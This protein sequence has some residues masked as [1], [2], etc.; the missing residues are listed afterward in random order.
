MSTNTFVCWEASQAE[1]AIRT[2]ALEG[3]EALFNAVHTPMVDIEVTSQ[4]EL[5]V[6][7]RTSDVELLQRISQNSLE[8]LFC[9]IRGEHGAGKSHLIRWLAIN[10]VNAG[11]RVLLLNRAGGNLYQALRQLRDDLGEDYSDLFNGLEQHTNISPEGQ[12]RNF[13][14]RLAN[15]TKK[16]YYERT[17]HRHEDWLEKKGVHEILKH[18]VVQDN[19]DAPNR[20]LDTLMGAKGARDSILAKFTVEDISKLAGL[21]RMLPKKAFQSPKPIIFLKKLQRE[22]KGHNSDNIPQD[23][24][25]VRKLLEALNDRLRDAVRELLGFGSE[26][27]Q[28]I[29]RR[30]RERLKQQDRRLVLLLEDITSTQGVDDQLLD[31]VTTKCTAAGNEVL[32]PLISIVGITPAYYDEHLQ[33]GN[34][35]DR[36]GLHLSLGREQQTEGFKSVLSSEVSQLEFVARYLRAIR[37]EPGQLDQ[38]NDDGRLGPPPNACDICELRAA[39]HDSFGA[40]SLNENDHVTAVG[41]F[42]FVTHSVTH[43]FALLR[44]SEGRQASQTPRRML[45][46]VLGPSLLSP[47]DLT[48]GSFPHP[49]IE[50][51]FH[52][53]AQRIPGA[54]IRKRLEAIA[55]QD[56]ELYERLRRLVVWWGDEH[57]HG[58]LGTSRF[59]GISE[60]VFER[61]SLPFPGPSDT[62]SYVEMTSGF[63]GSPA[64]P[65][66]SAEEPEHLNVLQDVGHKASIKQLKSSVN[67]VQKETNV[68]SKSKGRVKLKPDHLKD[69]ISELQEWVQ[70]KQLLGSI[71]KWRPHFYKTIEKLRWKR[72][73]IDDWTREKM[74]GAPEN[75]F[76]EGARGSSKKSQ[77][78]IPRASWVADGM[79]A[80]LRLMDD[81]LNDV[82]SFFHMRQY[83]F[84]ERKMSKLVRQ[85][86]EQMALTS[87]NETRWRPEVTFAEVLVVRAWLRGVTT[88][89]VPLD[90]QW[91]RALD[92]ELVLL[93]GSQE[94][95]N[96]WKSTLDEL[97]TTSRYIQEGL[98][99]WI[100]LPQDTNQN[101]K[102]GLVEMSDIA[103]ALVRLV[104]ERSI[105]SLPGDADF[106]RLDKKYGLLK[107]VHQ[108]GRAVDQ[109]LPHL[110]ER[111]TKRIQNVLDK[112]DAY[113]ENL[114]I[115]E[116]VRRV[117]A[118]VDEVRKRLP[119][120]LIDQTKFLDELEVGL[121]SIGYSSDQMLHG[122]PIHNV[123][124]FLVL[125][126]SGS[127]GVADTLLDIFGD[128]PFDDEFIKEEDPLTQCIEAPVYELKCVLRVLEDIERLLD[129][130]SKRL[131]DYLEEHRSEAAMTIDVVH[132]FGRT[133]EARAKVLKAYIEGNDDA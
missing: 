109:H 49:R 24:E 69:A 123:E 104:K 113:T 71:D 64:P 106:G 119:N 4:N 107:R 51:S 133:V 1:R 78:I 111:E 82:D 93:P 25:N 120:V 98:T 23:A 42:P 6:G 19:W 3:S 108:W 37:A 112:L 40:Y 127:G 12:A 20:I 41:L 79:E 22:L 52:P 91:D 125:R 105:V 74:F 103:P 92:R 94:R 60:G 43:M 50:T 73:G 121:K 83:A 61:F 48:N 99:A 26:G 34:M 67:R 97:N 101:T 27:V 30:L 57:A 126:L 14:D 32:C 76:I 86:V 62:K 33:A 54:R 80:F 35:R 46:S 65:I 44:D 122:A 129:T 59:M 116:Y 84:Y 81:D 117:Q 38:W 102:K 63:A 132:E 7:E 66:M 72:L 10:W 124:E 85:H 18:P 8:H 96:S 15:S 77:F 88:P 56:G 39:C 100:G 29:F 21:G 90:E 47:D 5:V 13:L 95:V 17:E 130:L 87:Q 75:L 110:A 53:K 2:E 28:D 118:S 114:S 55:Q 70:G 89:S 31:A 16:G 11:D 9:V 45:Q 115:A 68:K 128:E 36:I 131:K 58:E